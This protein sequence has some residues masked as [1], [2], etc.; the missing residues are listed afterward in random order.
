M[1]TP[2]ELEKIHADI[3]RLRAETMK[4]LDP[5]PTSPVDARASIRD[6]FW[7]PQAFAIGL[8]AIVADLTVW[9]TKLLS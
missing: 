5:Q 4:R 2:S 8:F 7:Y 9:V 3:V 6:L 1:L